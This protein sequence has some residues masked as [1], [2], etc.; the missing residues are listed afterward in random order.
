[1]TYY[2]KIEGCLGRTGK[3][4]RACFGFVGGKAEC[5]KVHIEEG[6]V[7]VMLE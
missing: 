2:C 7:N 6:M 3:R 5:C 1:M 4:K